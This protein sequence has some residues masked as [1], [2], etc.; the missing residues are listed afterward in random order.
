MMNKNWFKLKPLFISIVVFF[1]MNSYLMFVVSRYIIDVD[2][3]N[4]ILLLAF[5]VFIILAVIVYVLIEFKI[6]YETDIH[7]IKY[8]S[9]NTKH[10]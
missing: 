7:N 1:I 6:R 5:E 9:R 10:K 4:T 3:R 2:I 8:I